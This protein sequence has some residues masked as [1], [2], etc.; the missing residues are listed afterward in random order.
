MVNGHVETISSDAAEPPDTR[1]RE[2]KDTRERVVPPP[3]LR[4]LVVLDSPYLQR[5]GK[6]WA[7]P[8]FLNT[9]SC[10][11]F[12]IRLFRGRFRAGSRTDG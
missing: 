12:P 4:T 10:R 1:E 7:S 8:G 5:D 9:S 3:G 11:I 2:R 6:Q